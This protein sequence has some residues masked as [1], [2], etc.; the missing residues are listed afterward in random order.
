[1]DVEYMPDDFVLPGNSPDEDLPGEY[2]EEISPGVP[3]VNEASEDLFQDED[4]E[5]EPEE[6]VAYSEVQLYDD[7]L[8]LQQLNT[9]HVD[10]MLILCVLLL[11]FGR[12][13]LSRVRNNLSRQGGV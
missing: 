3:D 7:A 6:F 5:D 11:T 10:L 13:V 9:L 4:L 12:A 2:L 8:L 1:M